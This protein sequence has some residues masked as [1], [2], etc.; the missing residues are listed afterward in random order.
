MQI[1]IWFQNRR[2][3]ERREQS[4]ASSSQGTNTS[5]ELPNDPPV[6][7]IGLSPPTQ[8]IFFPMLSS[9]PSNFIKLERSSPEYTT[10]Q[11][12]EPSHTIDPHYF[13]SENKR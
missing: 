9:Q 13:L 2:A 10:Q 6:N 12:P 1:K 4:Q 11:M 8:Q 3:R 5:P 7:Q